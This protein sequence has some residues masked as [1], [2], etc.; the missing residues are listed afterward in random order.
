MQ[1]P[2][3][4]NFAVVQFSDGWRVIAEGQRLGRL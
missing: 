2:Q 1:D 3:P 4:A